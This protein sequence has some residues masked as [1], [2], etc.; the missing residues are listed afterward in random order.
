M[1]HQVL[2][3]STVWVRFLITDHVCCD[4]V[5]FHRLHNTLTKIHV[6]LAC[7]SRHSHRGPMEPGRLMLQTFSSIHKDDIAALQHLGAMIIKAA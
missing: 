6:N 7:D 5:P 4:I 3:A 2:E 1:L